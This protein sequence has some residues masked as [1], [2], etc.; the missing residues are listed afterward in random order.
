LNFSEDLKIFEKIL[1]YRT[2]NIRP[3][4]AELFQE[5]GRTDGQTDRQT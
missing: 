5:G 1:K 2:S 3:L 4:G